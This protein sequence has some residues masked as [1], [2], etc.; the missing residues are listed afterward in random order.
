MDHS[1]ADSKPILMIAYTNYRTDPR[2]IR[3][4][5]AASSSG[6]D[7]DLIVLRRPGDPP[8]ESINGVR[9]IH[10]NQTRYRGGGTVSYVLAYLEFFLRCI[11]KT[12]SLQLRKRYAAVHV[13]NM[14]DFFVF[15]ALLPKLMGAKVLLDIHDPMPNTFASKFRSGE[16]GLFFKILLWQERLSVAFADQVLTVHEPVKEYVLVKQH[17]LRP[18]AIEVI[19]NFP[20]GELFALKK[21]Q[22]ADGRLRLVFHGT[23]LERCGLRNAMLALA[24]MHHL[25]RV[26]VRIIGEG[27]FSEQLKGLI[28]ELDLGR[29]VHFDNRMYPLAEI[30]GLLADCNLGLV[31]LEI[32]SITNYVLPLKLLEYLSLG[33][34][35]VTVRNAAI[36]YYF[37]E[38]DCLFYEPGDPQSL[39]AVLDRLAADPGLLAHY[40]ERAVALR[41]KFQWGNERQKYIGLLRGLTQRSRQAANKA[42]DR[43]HS[44]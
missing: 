35:S 5:E 9:V 41:G 36:G 2:V 13:H 17:K 19:A 10:L 33:L 25:D 6:F 31:P 24:G 18:D 23:I 3:A 37:S 22:P 8:E 42:P 29:V 21:R 15:C 32:S 1:T 16:N 26:A 39:R 28:G 34:P 44:S 38:D 40:Q 14:P 7:V 43:I 20:D 4:A 11:F 27:D 30:P 12:A